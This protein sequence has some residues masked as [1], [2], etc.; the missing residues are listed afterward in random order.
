[1]P[2]ALRNTDLNVSDH[3]QDS[4]TSGRPSRELLL[5]RAEMAYL[6]SAGRQEQTESAGSRDVLAEALW[7]PQTAVIGDA[8]ANDGAITFGCSGS[9]SADLIR[10]GSRLAR[11]PAAEDAEF[12]RQA[13]D[14][15]LHHLGA[16]PPVHG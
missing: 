2:Y 15:P 7:E 13:G 10:R 12:H 9:R 11:G 16:S 6:G 5:C 4:H 8:F 14:A 3:G 1:M